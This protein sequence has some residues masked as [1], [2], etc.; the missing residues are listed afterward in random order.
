MEAHGDYVFPDAAAHLPPPTNCPLVRSVCRRNLVLV[1]CP[2]AA[3]LSLAGHRLRHA[4][5]SRL[6]VADAAE[7]RQRARRRITYTRAY[8]LPLGINNDGA[9]LPK[10]GADVPHW[11]S[12]ERATRSGCL[13]ACLPVRDVIGHQRARPDLA[14]SG[15]VIYGTGDWP[16]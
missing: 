2:R 13:P 4:P 9:D 16:P 1:N 7:Y 15:A 12:G 10:G 5:R 6:A 11:L 3:L 14:W 8:S